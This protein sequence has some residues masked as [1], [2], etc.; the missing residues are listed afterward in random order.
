MDSIRAFHHHYPSNQYRMVGENVYSGGKSG[1]VQVYPRGRCLRCWLEG[2][3][4]QIDPGVGVSD[5]RYG[6]CVYRLALGVCL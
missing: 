4:A 6:R 5:V 3:Y 2:G 1:G